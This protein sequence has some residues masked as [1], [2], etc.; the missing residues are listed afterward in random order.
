[1]FN[2]WSSTLSAITSTVQN[3]S[4][5][6]TIQTV[7]STISKLQSSNNGDDYKIEFWKFCER[8][9]DNNSTNVDEHEKWLH[10]YLKKIGADNNT[11]TVP[12]ND[13]LLI[14]MIGN[15]KLE[16]IDVENNEY[17]Y[18][19]ALG[20]LQVDNQLD[21]IRFELVPHVLD[22]RSFWINY[23]FRVQVLYHPTTTKDNVKSRLIQLNTP[24]EQLLKE[25]ELELEAKRHKLT[26]RQVTGELS[27]IKDSLTSIRSVLSNIKTND[28]LTEKAEAMLRELTQS[29]LTHKK[30]V[31]EWIIHIN[32]ED[33]LKDASKINKELSQF[34]LDHYAIL[35]GGSDD[36]F[37]DALES[38]DTVK[39]QLSSDVELENMEQEVTDLLAGDPEEWIN[40]MKQELG[41]SDDEQIQHDED[42]IFEEE[43]K[44][45]WEEED[46]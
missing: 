36:D 46:A 35:R 26:D 45:P 41:I 18:K 12:I 34:L 39:K 21:A 14:D 13:K 11:F 7:Q 8:I 22:E 44:L 5:Q 24:S 42:I 31:T 15:S 32:N 38:E 3:I 33:L 29:A 43:Q 9:H 6:D 37:Q 25:Q 10:H 16:R 40:S 2:N 1:M 19:L 20:A 27:R 30:R 28:Q 23:F 17:H 4:L